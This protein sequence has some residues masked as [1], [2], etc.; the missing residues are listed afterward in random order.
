VANFTQPYNINKKIK[1]AI[2]KTKNSFGF[3]NKNTFLKI[4]KINS[5]IKIANIP[6]AIGKIHNHLYYRQ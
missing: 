4:K 3:F 5:Q 6:S 1:I 2:S